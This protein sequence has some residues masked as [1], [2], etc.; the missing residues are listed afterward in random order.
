MF[1]AAFA[2]RKPT[3]SFTSAISKSVIQLS[4]A[5]FGF[6]CFGLLKR[7]DLE[8]RLELGYDGKLLV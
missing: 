3:K 1:A 7:K 4:L 2:F 5:S 8:D 6:C